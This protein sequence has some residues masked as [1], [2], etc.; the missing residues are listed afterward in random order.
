ML[1]GR[2]IIQADAVLVCIHGLCVVVGVGCV[3]VSMSVCVSGTGVLRCCHF[4]K[5]GRRLSKARCVC[6]VIGWAC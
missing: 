1:N 5:M 6:L 2:V 4:L 3:C